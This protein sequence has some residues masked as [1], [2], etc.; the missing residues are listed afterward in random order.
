MSLKSPGFCCEVSIR[1]LAMAMPTGRR[2]GDRKSKVSFK[3]NRLS[4]VAG[5]TQ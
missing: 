2:E 1:A 3:V 5:K 4:S